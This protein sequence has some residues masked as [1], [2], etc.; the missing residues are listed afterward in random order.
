MREFLQLKVALP[1]RKH[2][3]LS[4]V[5][6]EIVENFLSVAVKHE[7][8]KLKDAADF[9]Y[10]KLSTLVAGC[11]VAPI[12]LNNASYWKFDSDKETERTVILISLRKV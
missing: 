8:R 7:K 6:L 10:D 9:G 1:P 11:L 3:Q 12:V 5:E 2:W 4:D